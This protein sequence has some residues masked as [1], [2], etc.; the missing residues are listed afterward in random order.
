MKT[1][2]KNGKS[3][4]IPQSADIIWID[5]HPQ[6]GH[7]QKGRRPALVLSPKSYNQKSGLCVCAPITSKIKHYPFE[8]IYRLQDKNSAILSDQVK[9]IDFSARNAE[10]FTQCD[11][12]TMSQVKENIALLLE[13]Y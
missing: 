9:S 3:R 2:T 8:V 4:Y 13:M 12:E 5:F 10:F 7:E 1:Q 6:K 11:I